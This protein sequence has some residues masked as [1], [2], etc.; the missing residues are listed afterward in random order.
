[1]Q[2]PC[3]LD[4]Q[5]PLK[6]VIW[7]VQKIPW[8]RIQRVGIQR[9]RA[10]RRIHDAGPCAYAHLNTSEILGGPGYWFHQG[11]K[12]DTHC[13]ELSGTSKEF[14]WSTVLGQRLSCFNRWPRRRYCPGIHTVSGTRGSTCRATE[15]VQIR[16]ATFEV[17]N[18][19]TALSGS[20]F[21]AS[22]FAGGNLTLNPEKETTVKGND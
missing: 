17:A 8:A 9:K 11:Q 18:K 22:G 16:Y 19:I 7:P 2:I 21:Q 3:G 15:P 20:Q 5:I 4:S 14:H 10:Y 12:C 1:M 6:N 13:T